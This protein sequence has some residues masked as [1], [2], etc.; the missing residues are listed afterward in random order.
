[1]A[2]MIARMLASALLISA[3]IPA[4]AETSPSTPP[5]GEAIALLGRSI[6]YRSVEGSS[7][8]LRY[9]EHLAGIL[10][11]GGIVD[12]DVDNSGPAPTLVAIYQGESDEKPIILSGH[13]DVVEAKT[14]DWG[15]DPFAMTRDGDYLIGRGAVDNKWGVTMMVMTLLRLK[16]EGFTPRRDI[17]LALSGDEE[18][19]MK[20]TAILAERFR[21]AGLVLNSD[22]GG[23]T[24]REDGSPLA[25]NLQTAEKT[26]ADYEIAFTNPGGHS[27]RPSKD[28]AIYRL[29]RAIDRIGA[30]EFPAQASETTVEF[31]RQTGAMTAGELGKAMIRFA[32]NLKDKKAVRALRA[33]PE[34]VGQTGTTCVATMLA[35][36]H[37]LNA[38]P[39]RAAVS[40]NCRIFPGV[41]PD[42]VM[43]TLLEIVDDPQAEI[44]FVDPPTY[45]DASPMRED[46][47]AALRKAVDQRFPG[48]AIIPQM[49]AGATDSLYFRA[50]GVPS[51]G[52]SGLFMKPSD[53]F[54][55]GL[56]ERAPVSAVAGALDH[57]HTLLTE[58][59]Q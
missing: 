29:A 56:N 33:D 13:M 27:S 35:G 24:L 17:I 40:V 19:L 51:Y 28:N 59:A 8:T 7:D 5:A 22:G 37:A 32:D 10:K 14:E 46:V 16:R 2:P 21:D 30:Y 39:Q 20:S 43:T 58:I 31:F 34:Y 6:A 12:V 45:S 25:Y 38:L 41:T 48:L 53:D 23:G 18:T 4:A 3:T 36:G 1:M 54:T 15:R 49:S 55:H 44:R 11:K 26:Y 47:V 52:V 42:A 9:A 57:W 50:K